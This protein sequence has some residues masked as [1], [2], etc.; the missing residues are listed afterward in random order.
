MTIGVEGALI[1][2]AAT[3]R[4]ALVAAGATAQQ[5]GGAITGAKAHPT[6]FEPV[7]TVTQARYDQLK[8]T[9]YPIPGTVFQSGTA[10]S[11][12][13]PG[14][15]A[16][17]VGTVG[18]VTAQELSQLGAPYDAQ[19][20]V[21]QTG[22]EQADERQLAGTPGATVAVVDKSGANLATLAT[23]P[24]HPGTPV[25]TT[26]DPHVQRAAEAALGSEKKSAAPRPPGRCSPWCP[27]TP[28]ASIRPSTAASRPARLSR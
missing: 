18:P 28:A 25:S 17:I 27:S 22:L 21:G 6:Y 5:A 19:I 12:A 14:L 9:I 26:I 24:S 7:F 16:G 2:N 1:K 15:A 13:T 20:D 23:L 3:L 11:A 8:P 10:L 4:S